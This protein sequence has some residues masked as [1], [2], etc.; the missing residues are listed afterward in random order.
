MKDRLAA[1]IWW[2]LVEKYLRPKAAD[3]VFLSC[4]KK[5]KTTC[6][7]NVISAFD[8]AHEGGQNS[9]NVILVNQLII[10]ITC[11]NCS[12]GFLCYLNPPWK[13]LLE[14]FKFLI[15]FACKC[16]SDVCKT[17]VFTSLMS[18]LKCI[19]VRLSLTTPLLALPFT[20]ASIFFSWVVIA[21][22]Y[23]ITYVYFVL[24][25]LP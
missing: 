25:F 16:S 14:T 13:I 10:P 17:P 1:G 5:V 15:F 20:L 21:I 7:R 12:N 24:I 19:S 18:F 6:L 8:L 22:T 11:H 23:C 4:H 9:C 2:V 3:A